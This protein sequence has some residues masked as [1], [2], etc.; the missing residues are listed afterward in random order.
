MDIPLGPSWRYRT[1]ASREGDATEVPGNA[2]AGILLAQQAAG[3]TPT[4]HS[5]LHIFATLPAAFNRRRQS[6]CHVHLFCYPPACLPACPQIVS[7]RNHM[8]F[9]PLLASSC[10]G[11]VEQRSVTVPVIDIQKALRSPKVGQGAM[12]CAWVSASLCLS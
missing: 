5:Y 3:R 1:A 2:F 6:P 7:P 8:V 4:Y 9:T 12:P 11:T 10:V